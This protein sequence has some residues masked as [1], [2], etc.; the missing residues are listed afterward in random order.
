MALDRFMIA[1]YTTGLETDVRPWLIPDNAFEELRNAYV[2]RGRVVKRFGSRLMTGTSDSAND[3]EQ[4]TSRLRIN[5]ATTDVNGDLAATVCPGTKW[6]VGQLFSVGDEI[7]TVYQANGAMLSTGAGTGTYNTATGTVTIT[8]ATAT[9]DVYF[10]PAQPVMGIVTYDTG[11]INDEPVYAF[12]T[13]FSYEFTTAGW[14]RLGTATWSGTDSNFFWSTNYRGAANYDRYLFVTN[15]VDAD[16]IKYWNGA[17]WTNLNPDINAAGDKLIT[18]RLVIAFKNRI[19]ALNTR[20]NIAASARSFANRCRFSQNGDPV[21]ATAWRQDIVGK[22]NYIDAPT[23]E[24]II[25][26]QF[27]KDRLIVYFERSTYELAYTGNQ[28]GPFVWQKINTE[29]GAESTFSQ[30]PFD[31]VVLGVGNV[32]I[33]ACNGASV[34]RIDSKIPDTV[35]EIH[36]ENN[37]IDRVHGIRDY[38]TEMVYWSFPAVDQSTIQPFP[39]RVLVYNYRNDSWAMNDDSFTAFGYYQS[40]QGTTW[41]SETATWGESEAM[42]GDGSLQAKFRNVLAGNQ[43]GFVMIIDPTLSRNSASLQIT[44]MTYVGLT[45]TVVAIDHNMRQGEYMLFEH[46][47]GDDASWQD[48]KGKIYPI[49]SIVDKDTFTVLIDVALAGAY[50]GGGTLARV[51]VIDIKTKQF[52]FYQNQGRNVYIPQVDFLVD[53]TDKGAITADYFIGTNALSMIGEASASLAALGTNVLETSP[54]P[55]IPFEAQQTRLWHSLYFQAAGECVQLRLY[56]SDKQ[57]RDAEVALSDFQLHAMT[58]Y[59]QQQGRLQ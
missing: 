18:A 4:L 15:F 57:M 46:I 3:Y 50:T 10:Y 20:E 17:A 16:F 37:G 53:R 11:F 47:Q 25:T 2:F 40:I 42:W 31:K 56:L 32:G 8:G 49:L 13:Q 55:L 48:L 6:P 35:F 19:L 26:A 43:E 28:I 7:F 45:L 44:Q 14:E 23:T 1:P 33:H 5:I 39:N 41:G 59:A 30:V 29:L 38:A 54:Y 12:D 27:V 9:T 36:N 22:G 34:E 58:F 21:D 51:S 52:N 24:S